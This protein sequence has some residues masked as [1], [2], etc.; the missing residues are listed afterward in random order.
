MDYIERN[1]LIDQGELQ[2]KCKVALCDFV[3]YYAINGTSLIQDEDLKAKTEQFITVCLTD[4]DTYAQKVSLLLIGSDAYKQAEEPLS[5][6]A[7]KTGIDTILA[8]A[9]DYILG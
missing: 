8:N 6:T 1:R 5:D 3:N 4:I 2:A 9:L 7:I